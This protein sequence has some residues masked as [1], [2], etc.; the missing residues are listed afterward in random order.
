MFSETR[1][2]DL[3]SRSF[4]VLAPSARRS[5]TTLALLVLG[6]LA[7][8]RGAEAQQVVIS[9][10][11]GGSN[12]TGATY[13]RD[14]V[15]LHN[16]GASAVNLAN[17][18]VQY[19]SSAGSSWAARTITAGTI[20][21][22]GY[23]LIAMTTS[24]ATGATFTA[25][26]TVATNND[27]S[28]SAG[29]VALVSATAALPAQLA[30]QIGTNNIQDFVGY[31]Q[32]TLSTTTGFGYEGGS[33]APTLSSSLAAFRANSG[34]QQTHDNAADFTA[35]T[36]APRNTSSAAF[37]CTATGACCNGGIGTYTTSGACTGTYQGDFSLLG[38]ASYA[39]S[40]PANALDD[41]SGTGTIQAALDNSDDGAVSLVLG[42]P[43][44]FFGNRY[45]NISVGVNGH[46]TFL[47]GTT[48]TAFTNTTIPNSTT[49]N[50][51][52]APLWMD[53]FVRPVASV[54]GAHVYTQ[55]KTSPN[56]FIV[57]WNKVS[58][59]ASSTTTPDNLTFQAILYQDTGDVEVRYGAFNTTG[60]TPAFAATIGVEDMSGLVGTSVAGGTFAALANT[61]RL[62]SSNL[63]NCSP[64]ANDNCASATTIAAA[65]T[66][67]GGVS[68]TNALAT[69]DG[70]ATAC[71][72][73]V[74]K[75]VW[76][77]IT[78]A[79]SG[80]WD[81][82]TCTG[83]TQ[84][85][86]LEV[87][88]TCGSA[89]VACNDDSCGTQ[90][91]L[92][93]TFTAGTTY[94]IRVAG[95]GAAPAGG[96]YTLVVRPTPPGN[97]E[98][99]GAIAAFDGVNAYSTTGATDT[100]SP[101]ACSSITK[102]VWYAY[103]ATTTGV[104]N[105][106]NCP[107]NQAGASNTPS[108]W[109][110][111]IGIYSG[112][113]GSLTQI[114]CVDGGGACGANESLATASVVSGTTYYIR[115]GSFNTVG[116]ATGTFVIAPPAPPPANDVCA[117]AVAIT[118]TPY[119][120]PASAVRGLDATD[121]L[122]VTCN[123]G[124]TANNGVWFTYTP[125][126]NGVAN[127]AE[128]SSADTATAIFTGSCGTLTQVA[129][130]DPETS[131]F[132]M[133]AGTQYW[134]LVA[135]WS[136]SEPTVN[137]GF[138]FDFAAPP[139]NDACSGATLIAVPSVTNGTTVNA[140]AE[141]PLP[142]ACNGPTGS[143]SQSLTQTA[144]VW[145]RVNVASTQTVTLDTLATAYDTK[146]WVYTGTCGAL[147]CVTFNDD[148]QGTP[149]QSKV[150]FVATAG[151][152]YFVLVGPFSTTTGAF[153]L[154]ASGAATPANDSCGTPTLIGGTAGSI[155]GTTVG[156][157]GEN[158]TSSAAL[159][160]CN[161]AYSFFDV[162]Y[163]YTAPC[164]G[165][166]T[167]ST[168]GSYDTILSV[169]TTCPTATVNNQISGACNNDGPVGCTPGS[170]Y[171]LAVTG[172][173]TYLIR[174]VGNNGAAAGNAFTLTWSLPDV[175]PPTITT[176][177]PPQ[178]A[179]ANGSCQALVP[180]FTATTVASDNC[181]GIVITQSPLAGT[182]VG[183]GATPVTITVTDG[184]SNT[185]TCGTT[186]TVSDTTPPTIT[187]C[188]SG[189]SV[190]VSGGSCDA[191]VPD[192]AALTSATDA[193]GAPLITQSPAAGTFVGA[194]VTVVTITATDGA[195]NTATCNAN[196]TVTDAPPSI[197]S[198]APA[199]SAFADAACQ[200]AVPDF[201]AGTTATD[202]CTA[203]LS[204]SPLAGTLV[205]PGV[206]NVTITATDPG[207]Q[208]ATCGASFT[209]TDN[210]PP[211]IATCAPIQS[212]LADN[213]CQASVPDFTATT[214][215]SDNCGTVVLTQVPAAGA[216]VGLGATAITITATDGAGN[217][218][219]CLSSFSVT[220][221]DTDLD[222][223]IDCQDGCP[224]DP[225]K[226]APGLCGCGNPDVQL[227][228]YEDV[229]G[230][231]YGNAAVTQL[232]CSAPMGYVATAGDCD[233]NDAAVNPGAPEICFNLVDDD[234]NGTVDDI[235]AGPVFNVTQNT[236][237]CTIQAAINDASAGDVITVGAGTYAE[238]LSIP[239]TITLNG[240]N[241][242]VDPC[243]G[244]RGA[245]TIVIPAS[246]T[247]TLAG[248][249]LFV[250]VSA[251]NV[252]IDGFTFDGDN[253]SL[254]SPFTANGANPDVD[255]GISS[256]APTPG[257]GLVVRNNIVENVFQF[258]IALGSTGGPA[259][260]GRVEHNRVENVPYWAGV[261]V[262]D[263]YYAAIEANCIV[264][265]WRGVQTNNFYQAKPLG[266][267]ATIADNTITTQTQAIAG[268]ATYTDVGGILVNL[269]YANA[270]TWSVTGNTVT[271]LSPGSAGSRGIEVWSMLSAVSLTIDDNDATDFER[272]YNL[273]NAPTTSTITVTGGTVTGG[274]QGVVATNYDS[275]GDA[276]SSSY[277]I[278]RVTI[279]GAALEG[280]LVVDDPANTNASTV[281]AS[282]ANCDLSGNG[283]GIR[284]SGTTGDTTL[285]AHDN[286]LTGSATYAIEN[287][288]T[289]NL[290]AT[291]NWYGTAA[292]QL[293]QPLVSG[294]VTYTPWLV[295]GADSDL[296]TAGFQPVSGVCVGTPV[297][298]VLTSV[299]DLTCPSGS[300]GAVDVTT[301]GGS[302]P[303]AWLWSNG[304]VT[305]DLVG[306][307]AGA[308]SVTVTDAN[309]ST[310]TVGATVNAG[311][312]TTPPTI[313][314][315]AP[316][317]S[318]SAGIGCTAALPDFTASTVA[319]DDCGPLTITQVPAAGTPVGL[320]TTA[321]VVTVTDG[322]GNTATCSTSFSVSDTTPPSITQGSIASC[323]ATQSAAEAAAIAATTAVDNCSGALA[324]SSVVTTG[325][326]SATITLTYTDG[327][328]NSSM[329]VY[330]T[331][332]DPI[333][334]TISC[335]ANISVIGT[336]PTAVVVPPAIANDNC[337][338]FTVTNSFNGTA[339][340][341][342]LYPIGVTTVVFTVTDACGNSAN[343]SMTVTVVLGAPAMKISQ[344][345]GGG[346]QVGAP[347]T[348]D[349]VELYNAG[350]VAQT[351]TNWGL[352]MT[353]STGTTW[354]VVTLN[355]TVN[356]GQ[357]YLVGLATGTSV[358]APALPATDATGTFDLSSSATVGNKIALTS[359]NVALTG[360]TPSGAP[361]VDFVGF[362]TGANWR[363]PFVGG[364]VAN[365]APGSTSNHAIWRLTCGVQD[366]DNNAAD[367]ANDWP[368]PRNLA[369]TV[370]SGLSGTAVAFPYLV[371]GGQ[372]VRIVADVYDCA[373]L[374][375]PGG[376]TVTVNLAA[377]GGSAAQALND[378]G[379]GGDEIAGDGLYSTSLV[380]PLAQA[381][382]TY[383]LPVSY[384][385][386]A[387]T[388]G[389]YA[390]LLVNPSATPDNDNCVGATLVAG[391][392]TPAVTVSGNL[393]G[394]T[395]ETNPTTSSPIAPT[396]G[397]SNRRGLWHQVTGTGNTLTAAHCATTP[398]FD[399]VIL[400]FGG[401]CDGMTQVAAGDDNCG[402]L[403][404]A[405]WCSVAGAPYWIYSASFSTGAQTNAFT[406]TISDSGV[407]CSTA[408]P[409]TVCA[410]N[411][412]P[413]NTV[414]LEP[415]FGPQNNDGCD[416]TPGLF[417]AVTPSFP[418]A[419]LRGTARGFGANRDVDWYRFQA[420]ATDALTVSLTAQFQGI[421]E[422]RQL[423][424]TGT[425]STNTLVAQSPISNRCSTTTVSTAVTAGNWYAV[426]IL[427]IGA[428]TGLFGGVFP[429][430][431]SYNYTAT[432]QLGGPPANDLCANA[433]S[434][435]LGAAAITG[436]INGQ[437]NQDGTSACD[438]S[439]LDVWYR[440][441]LTAPS[442]TLSV[443][444]CGS[445]IDTVLSVYATCGGAQLGCNDDCGGTP[446]GATSSCLSISGLTPGT[447]FVRVSN[448]G[449]ATGTFQIKASATLD[450]DACSGGI[451]ITVPSVNL[452]TTVGATAESPAPPAC[453]G[454]L[455]SGSQNFTYTSGV[456]YRLTVPTT[457]TVTLDT[458]AS[459]YDSKVWVFDGSSGCGALTCVTA[460]DDI[461]GSPF[462]SK[463]SFVALA[464][465][466][467]RVLV[468]PF[469]GTGNFT[470][471][472]TGNP[473]PANDLCS[474]PATIAGLSGSVGGTTVGAT[475]ENNT[476]AAAMPSCN[477]SYGFFDVW[478]AY[479]APCTGSLTL[480][481]CGSY[482][483]VLSVHSS[484]P[485]LTV[486]NEIAGSCNNDGPVGCTPGSQVT[487]PVAGGTTYLIRVVGFAG[488]ANGNAFNLTWSLLDA[489]PPVI[490]ACAPPATVNADASCQA[491]IPSL[492]G[493]VIA[494]DACSG[495]TI[496]QSP[497]A[498]TTVGLGTTPVTITVT[499][500]A[501][502]FATCA[503]SVLVVD[504]TPPSL[505]CGPAQT[506]SADASCLG[507]VPDV[508][509]SATASDCNG[510]SLS[511]SPAA[512]TS[513]PLGTSSIT[514][515]ATDGA[516]N[517]STCSVALTVVDTTPPTITTCASG[518]SLPADANCQASIPSLT[519]QVVASDACGGVL[520][521]QIPPAGTV[522]GLGT[523]FVQLVVTDGAGNTAS[524]LASV[525][526]SSPDTDGDGTVD[527]QDGCPSD[528]AKIAPGQCGCGIVD[529]DTDSDTVADCVDN[530]D[531][532]P[533]LGQE[534]LDGDGVGDACDNCVA[535]AN[536][537]QGDCDGDTIGDTCEIV[538][539]A[540]DCNLNG[541]PDACDIAS[542]TSADLNANAIP[543]ECEVNGGTPFCFG[544]AGCPCGNNSAPGSGQ[545]CRN[546][547]GL[548]AM[549]V[550]SGLTSLSADGLVLSVTHLPPAGFCLFFQGDAQTNAPFADGRRC[551]AGAVVRLATKSHA[552]F[553]SFPQFGD[554][555]VHTR[556]LVAVPGVRTYQVWYR[557]P[558]GPCHTGS[559]LSNGLSVIWVP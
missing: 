102:D 120:A 549:L 388:G 14:F 126:T 492:V 34:C 411:L 355:G 125:A 186:F 11:Y 282:I 43:M 555:S 276:D 487:L 232:A 185:A 304:A 353:T 481:T 195:G 423:G 228:F 311:V 73:S 237:F 151:V 194:G 477:G 118:S 132:A 153:T 107:A 38:A 82:S 433:T 278:E 268:D 271:N 241:A 366:V 88:T 94:R 356:P 429:G 316:S 180:D 442:S 373:S 438:A 213:V 115:L 385:A 491:T 136:T 76:F 242:G 6:S 158:N 511:Q 374:V 529:T 259:L 97:D 473:T 301:S 360:G 535:Y 266:S 183:L 90:S 518:A 553:S 54:P 222:G 138:T 15:E 110:S 399:S 133:T 60:T 376:T 251:P 306:V 147:S 258:G 16:R 103:T 190:P 50:N 182:T 544:Y 295:S 131:T 516:G 200:A 496:T 526:V 63:S 204:Q 235:A 157:T 288:D 294:P 324:P 537:T 469:S 539:G 384:A 245:E 96:S 364:A 430:A 314:T 55:Q 349:Y 122:D 188:A 257:D 191:A 422:I 297:S 514:V 250:T 119:T 393:T 129:C 313:T 210:T 177:A 39:V 405:S 87:Y 462:Q 434:L 312:D 36:P 178:I 149:F 2:R 123:S 41:I 139:A 382:G 558:A 265:A 256:E 468:A 56:R 69:L 361:I 521:T 217:T 471:T 480:G 381:V 446:C 329:A 407:P 424:P 348:R 465:V 105:V 525:I 64:P 459:A 57:Q 307:M 208:T 347:L 163:S 124:T 207:G 467:Y 106:T 495:I 389:S 179:S 336:G 369:T 249:T 326:C 559:N 530:C 219:T 283:V 415:G 17:W 417:R 148:I 59:R 277:A 531:T 24:G 79:T 25:D 479:T 538:V 543:D 322:S 332:I 334:P 272:G 296:V 556:G 493:S 413:V 150:A 502:N 408:L 187:L 357:Y 175:T 396:T 504:V 66:G 121:D 550:G 99:G 515:T 441:A 275:Y 9:Q 510:V 223:T 135:N 377:I 85:T 370:N 403:A 113:C 74:G 517:F 354:T 45:T 397:I 89:V 333:A 65:G 454:P 116:T 472:A 416:S 532:L 330:S 432:V 267:S 171:V 33:S 470:L 463:V 375:T 10:V 359:T 46:V 19:A 220:S 448:K 206:T 464:G 202:E 285:V 437:T 367:F 225:L 181:S 51:I 246:G 81:V 214:S 84:D 174:V 155:A 344:V 198:C 184:A 372:T 302:T 365:N 420:A 435:T 394:A 143:G 279:N 61:A 98:C 363:E 489:T 95:K 67:A 75:D 455:G 362:G 239:T 114:S 62:F 368:T 1:V 248:T 409:V 395:T 137:Y 482:D 380:V 13:N 475:S 298:I 299:T 427:E 112:T 238:N 211:T 445:A 478:Y 156:A 335:P 44:P 23:F 320:G 229:D 49:T 308:Y 379:V 400:V 509:G 78:P 289:G 524:C 449:L 392:Y 176:C 321:V 410:P 161:G 501:G 260:A 444:T 310:A 8:I 37:N 22:G 293:I 507:S 52:I 280:I 404:S 328:S 168:C 117:G 108:G 337:S 236:Y 18:S 345:F 261:L 300:N 315:C 402:T 221:P 160:S 494:S 145:Y 140:T 216:V 536:P 545:G 290:D 101:A 172:G 270:S 350:N 436:L 111:V 47:P 325:S 551:A 5:L 383:A 476:A 109:D 233:D 86:V 144:G 215:A 327:A 452:G 499:D 264:D 205:G 104:V 32:T 341:S 7:L 547:T 431:Y 533:N 390:M 318:A 485:S 461:Q 358:V 443:D 523:T 451:A 35:A 386:G 440:V 146:V 512:G 72:T 466:D 58:T 262:Y 128:T 323:Y 503:T 165:N 253:P 263:D 154:T 418:A 343:C 255:V 134:I 490:T 27:M 252:V 212:A 70:S 520:V 192:Y 273:W 346:G 505:T 287:L 231:G 519:G 199:Q 457:Q 77:A 453:V 40:S 483:T 226:I 557:N 401:T 189:T 243:T 456:W 506:V 303:Y 83:T 142:P 254:T 209:V 309:G 100:T 152:D 378:A 169:H 406:L 20:A 30:F 281:A 398:T 159:P 498:G 48:A 92:S 68:G 428:P 458:L 21:P 317:L 269:H 305:E 80:S 286:S 450:N 218:A 203:T 474:S 29:K 391:P 484:C 166:V 331:R 193:C 426:R 338:G 26:F 201:T 319:S 170:Q 284:A 230:D 31:G 167:L 274:Q 234:C 164:T 387:S 127:L 351:M 352:Q 93:T 508:T 500:G 534:D 244:S 12:T 141:S 540:P 339:N 412:G 414:E 447:Y 130:S 552:S 247:A 224:A 162:W 91:F 528:P 460:N 497:A 486:S 197:T 541:I 488:A 227:T 439:G 542:L 527:C 3:V 240:A 554:L 546:S 196:F 522:V 71:G 291:C 371:E 548:G 425:C 28:G 292:S 53:M 419:T 173:S 342:G 4:D 513:V 42:T 340:A 421:A